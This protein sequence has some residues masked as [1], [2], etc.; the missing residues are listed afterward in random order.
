MN[1]L[2]DA[3]EFS[4][5]KRINSLDSVLQGELVIHVTQILPRHTLMKLEGR[6]AAMKN[7]IKLMKEKLV[8]AAEDKLLELLTTP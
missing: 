1:K 2:K 7:Y 6:P 3:I 5:V 4:R 8:A